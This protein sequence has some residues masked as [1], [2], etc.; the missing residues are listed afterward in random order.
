MDDTN[1]A[2]KHS[3]SIPTKAKHFAELLDHNNLVKN[4]SIK[5]YRKDDAYDIIMVAEIELTNGKKAY[6]TISHP[7]LYIIR[8]YKNIEVEKGKVY[9]NNRDKISRDYFSLPNIN[10]SNHVL[11]DTL[12]AFLNEYII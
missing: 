12:D 2:L 8:M 10:R 1:D 11:N 7:N 3:C 5:Q 9:V 4:Y 6:I